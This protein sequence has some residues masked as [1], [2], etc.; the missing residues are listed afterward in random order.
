MSSLVTRAALAF[1]RRS[2]ERRAVLFRRYLRPTEQDLILDVGSGDGAHIA[3]LIPF[4]R[5]VT[6]ADITASD[7]EAGK[8]AYGFHT[9][10]LAE[11]GPLPFPDKHFD[12]VFCSAVIEHVTVDKQDMY[13]Y[14][15]SGTFARA[16]FARQRAFANEIRRVGKRY[17]VATPHKYFPIESHTWLPFFIVFLP[18]RYQIMALNFFNRWWPKRTSPDW[19]LLTTKDMRE[20]FPEAEIIVEKSFGL[21]KSIIAIKR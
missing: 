20:L 11:G 3:Q 18:R 1:A 21:A 10:L 2:R 9:V 15:D 16:A 8:N 12:I 13:R 19:N 6:I 5:N 17:F 7:L 4:R 14:T